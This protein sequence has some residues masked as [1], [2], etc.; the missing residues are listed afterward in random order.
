MLGVVNLNVPGTL[1]L[2]M[3]EIAVPPVSVEDNR[4]WPRVRVLAVGS[5]EMLVG[6]WF[7]V[8]VTALDTGENWVVS[9]GVKVTLSDWVPAG[10]VVLGVVNAKVPGTDVLLKIAEPPVSAEEARVWP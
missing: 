3:V 10:G 4:V 9:L 1:A 8:S 2:V 5:T 6:A 7:T